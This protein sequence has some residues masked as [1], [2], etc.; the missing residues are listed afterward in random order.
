MITRSDHGI[1]KG[2]WRTALFGTVF[3]LALAPMA[4]AAL[5]GQWTFNE[6]SGAVAT[7]TAGSNN[8]TVS[9][10]ASFVAS[11]PGNYAVRFADGSG[12]GTGND[13]VVIPD[14]P[15]FTMGPNFSIEAW[16]KMDSTSGVNWIFGTEHSYR[17]RYGLVVVAGNYRFDVGTNPDDWP[18]NEF[19]L[20]QTTAS[21]GV[22]DHLVGTFD[23]ATIKLY[24]NG[25]LAASTPWA[26][27]HG[28]YDTA[29]NPAVGPFYYATGNVDQVQLWNETLSDSQ[30]SALYQSGPIAVPEPASAAV[31]ASLAMVA[32]CSR[33]RRI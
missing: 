30:V 21:T 11:G 32:L 8:G 31:G 1:V 26:A 27:P 29:M 25:T 14:G 19:N 15:T 20:V 18:N 13:S 4:Q 17:S 12:S 9:N 5:I 10:G 6:G 7:D 33:R 24:K 22:W 28:V 3:S 16:V 23:G 2:S